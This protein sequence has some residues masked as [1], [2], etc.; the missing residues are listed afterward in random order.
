MREF[1]YYPDSAS[2]AP[3]LFLAETNSVNTPRLVD[4]N[5]NE[6]KSE[7]YRKLNPA[8]R[9]PT[10]M[11]SDHVLFESP[12]IC[13]YICELDVRSTLISATRPSEPSSALSMAGI[14]QQ[15]LAG[16]VY[17]VAIC[18]EPRNGRRQH[19]RYQGGSDAPSVR[20][21]VSIGSRAQG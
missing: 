9:I 3:H 4:R 17:V 1:H 21:Y 10:M 8:G 14:P 11:D 7:G 18:A 16:G 15:R 2:F 12:A 13:I 19:R 5:S 20:P 6:Q